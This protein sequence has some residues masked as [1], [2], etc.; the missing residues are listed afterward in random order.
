MALPDWGVGSLFRL[1][2]PEVDWTVAKS[3]S[4]LDSPDKRLFESFWLPPY[5]KNG[6]PSRP[7][8]NEH[9][10]IND[11]STGGLGNLYRVWKTV[12]EDSSQFFMNGKLPFEQWSGDEGFLKFGFFDDH[13]KRE[14][15]QESFNSDPRIGGASSSG[16]WQDRW[17]TRYPSEGHVMNAADIDVNYDGD[18][19]ISAW[20]TM[21]DV[22]VSSFLTVVGGARFETTKISTT[23]TDAD[24]GNLLLFLPPTYGGISFSGNEELANAKVSQK[25]VLPSIGFTL[26]PHDKWAFRGTYS[27]TIARM[28]FKELT[29]IQQQ[30]YLGG[31]VFIGNPGLKMS[32]L[33]NY[34][35]R[36]D[37]NP[38]PGG[39]FSFSWF[40]KKI[41]DPIEYRQVLL[42]STL[43]TTAENFPE[44]TI[45]GY[46]A[47]VR[48]A[49]G[50]LWRS[51]EGLSVGG[52]ITL[53][54]SE[55]QLSE[56]VRQEMAHVGA[57]RRSQP[58]AGC[59]G[60]PLQPERNLFASSI[61]HGVRPF[62]YRKR[63]HPCD[64]RRQC[65]W[66]F[67][68]GCLCHRTGGS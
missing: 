63:R 61:R 67:F 19:K 24:G 22:P 14:S 58:D 12:E 42:D 2:D 16:D 66:K 40:Y 62:L 68:T 10:Q 8:G 56:S 30:D 60:I 59:A 21:V 51:L 46:E 38:Y 33:K 15:R 47:E 37:Y 28:T 29:P 49:L 45:N 18:Q 55:V 43:A 32:S 54:D 4:R 25:D 64:G 7:K 35:L 53:I 23:I 5:L 9:Q 65:Q 3:T 26:V 1:L 36:L 6:D 50:R 17:S 20:Y 41:T 34:D 13:V 27:E 31:D 44:G 57:P 52:N 48:Q 39:L 11:G